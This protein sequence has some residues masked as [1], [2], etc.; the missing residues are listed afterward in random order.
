[1]AGKPHV[2]L[3]PQYVRDSYQNFMARVGQGT[4]NQHNGSR[5]GFNPITR[6]RLQLEWCYRGSW[7]C[8]KA[9]DCVAEDMT[10]E[11]VDI[12]SD[13]PPGK[14]QELE[15]EAD[16]RGIWKSLCQVIK[17]S[18][19]YGGSIGFLMIDG[20]DPS[21]PL[22]ISKVTKDQFK[23]I[24]PL[25]RWLLQ[26]SLNNLV[27]GEPGDPMGPDWGNPRFY[28]TVVDING[29]I[30]R[31]KIHYSRVIRLEGI[32]LPY[33]QRI[34][35]NLWGLSVLE[36]LWDRLIAFDSTTMGAAQLIYK[37]HL[38]TYKVAGLREIIDM[39]GD[40]LNGLLA[41]MQMVQTFQS[42][43]GL[44][45]M[46]ATD[47]FETHQYAFSGLDAVMLQFG[48]QL[49]GALDIPLVRLFGQSPAGLNATG[50][51]DLRNYLSGIKQRQTDAIGPGVEKVYRLLYVSTFGK[52]PPS[53]FEIEFKSL[54]E[55]SDPEKADMTQKVSTS[56]KDMF[57][58]QI[59]DKS[60]S[61]KELRAL[62]RKTGAFASI[63]DEM[64]QQAEE[65]DEEARENAP[66]PADLALAAAAGGDLGR[67][68]GQTPPGPPKSGAPNGRPTAVR[69]TA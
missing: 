62:S 32:E 53:S 12:H 30:P 8:G 39:G 26:P 67:A 68:P 13:D 69:A 66:D 44:T 22:D 19:L 45:I 4:G 38:R 51:S 9:I 5:Y 10:R 18:R 29:G 1:M 61:M 23:G 43:E 56:V 31:L 59:I 35:E 49:S 33:W 14:L 20:Q 41:Q 40:A 60:T 37:A 16:K 64:I 57:D 58:A 7:I 42:N 63:T 65:D 27:G 54:W 24:L 17:W 3:K 47:E 28:D 15:K 52:E 50:E 25:D 34:T 48:Q 36:R 11:G 6:I 55:L 21:T 46:D 2:K